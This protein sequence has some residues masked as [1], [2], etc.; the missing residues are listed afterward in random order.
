MRLTETNSSYLIILDIEN[1]TVFGK[2]AIYYIIPMKLMNSI[3]VC[4]KDQKLFQILKYFK[5]LL[6]N[7]YS[8]NS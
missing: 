6:P 3:H 8:F 4:V 7:T 2:L 5:Y 1:K